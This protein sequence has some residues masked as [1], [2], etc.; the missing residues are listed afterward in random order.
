[1]RVLLPSPRRLATG[2]LNILEIKT[3][4]PL[5]LMQAVAKKGLKVLRVVLEKVGP[6][7]PLGG[8]GCVRVGFGHRGKSNVP[9]MS[10]CKRRVPKEG[11]GSCML[12]SAWHAR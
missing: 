5:L 10:W 7:L 12:G 9:R 3:R 8:K 6:S 11:E 2:P 1:M 4:C